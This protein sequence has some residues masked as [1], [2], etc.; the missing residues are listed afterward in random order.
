MSL[1]DRFW[2]RVEKSDGCW[3]WQ[4]GTNGGSGHGVLGVHLESGKRTNR[5]VGRIAYELTRGPV[6]RQLYVCHHCDNP[7]CVRPDHLFLGTPADNMRDMC[8]KG[9]GGRKLN[10]EL[11]GEIR[12][13]YAA[14]GVTMEQLGRDYDTDIANIHRV[15]H[16]QVWKYVA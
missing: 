4:G 2:A 9:R 16:R 3:L 12:R 11:V 6:P 14:G 15:I 1:A 5:S 8:Q 13:A 10:P 7:R